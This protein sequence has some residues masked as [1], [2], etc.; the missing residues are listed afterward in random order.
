MENKTVKMRKITF[1]KYFLDKLFKCLVFHFIK[2]LEAEGV[3]DVCDCGTSI[4]KVELKFKEIVLA[5]H[6]KAPT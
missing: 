6:P 2:E 3:D 4:G 5:L 1:Y